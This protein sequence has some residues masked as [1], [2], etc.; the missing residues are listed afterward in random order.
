MWRSDAADLCDGPFVRHPPAY[1]LTIGLAPAVTVQNRLRLSDSVSRVRAWL[2]CALDRC[3]PMRPRVSRLRTS[4]SF[5]LAPVC[6]TGS[7]MAQRMRI[8]ILVSGILRA[9]VARSRA[10]WF[11]GS[12]RTNLS[13]VRPR[14]CLVSAHKRL[15]C[16]GSRVW[17][18][19]PHGTTN[20]NFAI[21]VSGILRAPVARSRTG[22]TI[23]DRV[24]GAAGPGRG[25]CPTA[26]LAAAAA[27]ARR[28]R[29]GA[30]RVL[31]D[32]RQ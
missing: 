18:G 3:E 26:S 1:G 20:E 12:L 14:G 16:V 21:L 7:R 22:C 32:M 9:P 19:G 15:S 6:G 17:D 28:L 24:G 29:P 31:P 4:A 25:G 5:L 2:V 27:A 11:V 10:D 30:T 8:A 23:H 13:L